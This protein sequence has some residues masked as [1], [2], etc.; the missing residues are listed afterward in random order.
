MAMCTQ[1]ECDLAITLGE[2]SAMWDEPI[3]RI[4]DAIDANKILAGQVTYIDVAP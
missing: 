2:L 4:M 1:V 3:P